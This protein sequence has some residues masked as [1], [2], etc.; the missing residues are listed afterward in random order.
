MVGI[1]GQSSVLTSAAVAFF[2]TFEGLDGSGKSTHLERYA[3]AL[4]ARGV[5]HLATREPG[6]TEL[7]GA[8]RQVFLDPRFAGMDGTVELLLVF[9]SRRQHLIEV[10]EP[11][12]AAGQHVL[13][14]RF[15]D[16]SRAYQGAGR[17]VPTEVIE[18]VDRIATGGRRPDRTLLFDLPAELARQRGHS[19]PRRRAGTV[20]RLDAEEL[21]F[22]ERVRDGFRALAAAEPLRF[23]VIDSSRPLAETEVLVAAALADLFPA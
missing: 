12:L 23:R 21:D 11:A 19:G 15:T 5:A 2:V 3:R 17:G 8:I 9:A 20:D 18:R 1:G 4:A 16:S 22:Y 13:C 6:G 14:D 10:V 7:G